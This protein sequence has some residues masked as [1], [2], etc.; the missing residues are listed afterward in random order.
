MGSF[1]NIVVIGASAG[2]IGAARE[3]V[4]QIPEDADIAVFVVIHLARRSNAGII[5]GTLQKH[6][7][8]ICKVPT[9][10]ERIE[11]RHLYLALQDHHMIIQDDKIFINRGARENKYRPSVDVLFRS[12]AVNY[13][14]SVIG[15]I[16]TGMLDDGT[17]GMSAIDRCGGITIVQD[18]EDAQFPDMPQSVL[19]QIAV[20]Y[21]VPL[22][23]IGKIL[24]QIFNK[25]VPPQV[26]VPRE[27]QI[28]A[29]ITKKMTS[30]I[31]QMK[32][33][34][35]HSDFVCPD[36]GGGLWAVRH[37]P[38][39]RYRCH[40]GHAFTEQAL[41]D[42][43]G[44]NLE[45]SVWVSIRMLEERRNLLLL[46]AGHS[47]QANDE[48]SADE[49]RRRSA[50]MTAHIEAMKLVLSKLTED[51]GSTPDVSFLTNQKKR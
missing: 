18:P 49:N 44:L 42:M 41:Y 46:M 51:V 36:C 31:N 9:T 25:P 45:E 7:S 40:T 4:A 1:R 34:G 15:I 33:I 39:Y 11:K 32:Q 8:L 20:D 37:D 6:T 24:T 35:D 50:E 47:E 22:K 26:P 43:Q 19:N 5:A 17:A 29:E 27:L 12:A 2:G 16:L 3:V 23:N 38:T 21:Q 48:E 13:G 28:E 10:G 30:S 14:S